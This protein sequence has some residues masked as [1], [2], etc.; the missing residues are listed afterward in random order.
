MT[1]IGAPEIEENYRKVPFTRISFVP[2]LARFKMAGLDG[3]II[4]IMRKR[5]YDSAAWTNK[6][7]TV[8]WNEQKIDIKSFERYIDLYIGS[9]QET[10]RVFAQPDVGGKCVLVPVQIT[11]SNKSVLLMVFVLVAVANT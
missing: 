5:A 11:T 1:V 8:Y 7:V 6:D 3:D 4:Q 9:K 10:K 2:D